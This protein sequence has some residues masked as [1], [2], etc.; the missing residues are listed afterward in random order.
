MIRIEK[1]TPH[2]GAEISGI[3][4]SRPIDEEA[5]RE[6]HRALMENL[7]VFFRDQEM[8]L[9]QQRE[10]GRRFGDL[11]VHP[12]APTRSE[13]GSG[14]SV[15][16]GK[17]PIPYV[18]ALKEFPEILALHAD[19]NSTRAAGEDWHADVSCDPEPPMGSIL[20]LT[21]VPPAGGDT[22]FSSM[23]AAYEA[24]SQPMKDLL[25]GLT[26]IHDGDVYAD[27]FR[28]PGKQYPRSEHPVVCTHPETGRRLLFVNSIF[29]KRIVQLSK[30]ESDALLG[31]LFRHVETAEFQC[32]FRWR[33][34]SVAFWDNRSVQHHA[35]WDYFPARRH[36]YRV[37]I[38]G[39][40]PFFRP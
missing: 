38:K 32:R 7:V 11:H 37:T 40:R 30:L 8:T 22:L 2:V 3:D 26:A 15:A 39:E 20:R 31:C 12:G 29:T 17:S 14:I 18:Y 13:E 28:D 23:Y 24:L 10:F 1:L 35:M 36:G 5:F 27:R 34:N 9:A 33:R 19:E 21:E 16:D 6:I 4:L 25:C